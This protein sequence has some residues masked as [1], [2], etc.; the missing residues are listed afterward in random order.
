M[1]RTVSSVSEALLAS[2][3]NALSNFAVYLGDGVWWQLTNEQLQ[4]GCYRGM[5]MKYRPSERP[6]P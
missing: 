1:R 4:S 6:H 3:P 5:A 2:Y